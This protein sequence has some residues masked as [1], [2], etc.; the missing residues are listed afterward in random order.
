M[1]STELVGG[2]YEDAKNAFIALELVH[3]ATLIHDDILDDDQYR[4]GDLSVP[5][6]YGTKIAVLTGD[7]LFS[8]GLK[9][10]TKT[11]KNSVVEWLS[12]A[13]LKMIQGVALQNYNKGKIIS[14]EEFLELNYLKSGSL[15][16]AAAVLGGLMGTE[17]PEALAKLAEFGKCFGNAYQVRDDICDAFMD[18]GKDQKSRNDLLNGD[19]S[20][21]FIYS[22]NSDNIQTK[23]KESLIS[24]YQGKADKFDLKK[25]RQI[26][27]ESLALE[28]TANKMKKYAS[29]A[30][31]ALEFFE[32][33]SAKK[34][35]NEIMYTY[36]LTFD[37]EE[38]VRECV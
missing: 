21:L 28:K 8:L 6:K 9:F 25:I 14:E 24:I 31:K 30:Q 7:T 33:S 4:R 15:F 38:L 1:L 29:M 3:N 12:D 34:A 19:A 2:N 36:Y 20:L 17:D 16:E 26:Y 37:S 27:K 5:Q 35:L 32:D 13:T 23:D 22:I 10:A 11:G 18:E